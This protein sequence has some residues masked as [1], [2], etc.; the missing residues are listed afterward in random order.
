MNYF[1]APPVDDFTLGRK[2]LTK[3]EWQSAGK[4][5]LKMCEALA[6]DIDTQ[7]TQAANKGRKIIRALAT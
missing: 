2:R 5:R 6:I 7:I 1:N 4:K 3:D